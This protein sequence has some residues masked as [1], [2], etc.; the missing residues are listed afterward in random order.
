MGSTLHLKKKTNFSKADKCKKKADKRLINTEF[1]KFCARQP[2]KMKK[3]QNGDS[4]RYETY[5]CA[6]ERD[7]GWFLM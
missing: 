6:R 3:K 1:S 5:A 7:P 4:K 2:V